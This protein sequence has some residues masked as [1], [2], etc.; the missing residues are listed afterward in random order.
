MTHHSG[1]R[2]RQMNFGKSCLRLSVIVPQPLVAFR[3]RS[4]QT[5]AVCSTKKVDFLVA[6]LIFQ[7]VGDAVLECL[8]RVVVGEEK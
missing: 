6:M 4:V 5:K 3:S 8:M 2:L 7:T 1:R